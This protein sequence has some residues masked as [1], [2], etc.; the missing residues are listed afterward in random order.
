MG[1][2]TPDPDA[3][4]PDFDLEMTAEAFEA[5]YW[6]KAELERICAL[7]QLSKAGSKAEL[8]AA[9]AHR[10]ANPDTPAP[11]RRP[12]TRDDFNWRTADLTPDTLITSSITFGPNVRGFFKAEIGK[13]F[14]CHG[15]FMDWVRAN[16]GARLRDAVAAWYML[17]RRKDDPGFRREIAEHNNFLQ[18]LRDFQDAYPDRSLEDAK[19]CWDQ[20]KIRPAVGGKVLFDPTDVRFLPGI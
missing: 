13:H 6:P 10:L 16:S 11:R 19:A 8:R 9:I 4:R 1:K 5:W 20:K 7:L 17:E 14:S 12:R 3:I 18:Y 2:Q 15:D